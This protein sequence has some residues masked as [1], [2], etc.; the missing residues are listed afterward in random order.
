M[1][2]STAQTDASVARHQRDMAEAK[3]G[4]LAAS[5]VR[6]EQALHRAL[7]DRKTLLV[8]VRTLLKAQLPASQKFLD[9][10]ARRF[11]PEED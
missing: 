7:L 4:H 9:R 8:L 5:L 1:R 2:F 6:S 10:I 11:G 3:S